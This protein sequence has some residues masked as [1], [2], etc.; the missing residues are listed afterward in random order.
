MRWGSTKSSTAQQGVTL[1][2]LMLSLTISS[3]LLLGLYQLVS[4]GFGTQQ[5]VEEQ[6]ELVARAQFAMA[7]MVEAVAGGGVLLVPMI[8]NPGTGDVESLREKT[9]GE[10]RGYALLAVTLD[11]RTDLDGDGIPD[12]DN[13]GDGLIDEDP[14]ADLTFDG[15]PGLRGF[16]DDGNGVADFFL[17]SSSD[18]DES[19]DRARDEDP[20][21]GIDDD[22]D[23]SI[24]EDPGADLNGDGAPGVLD[25]DDDG[26]GLVDE[27]DVE[28][29][30]EDGVT[31]EDWYDPVVFY[32]DDD[33]LVQRRAVPFDTSGD[34]TVTGRDYLEHDLVDGVTYLGFERVAVSD[35]QQP[36]VRIRLVLSNDNLATFELST[37]VRVGAR[38]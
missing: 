11:A 28:D 5:N 8:D 14:P 29:D 37:L 26:D 21:N 18:D 20:V 33:R 34:G 9:V 3:M 30:D 36:L 25:V 7:R 27:G 16:D 32:L 31:N 17:S 23:G 4:A 13:D 12:A 19:N 1:V 35:S 10:S 24:D 22:G 15:E 2:E 38:R 6:T